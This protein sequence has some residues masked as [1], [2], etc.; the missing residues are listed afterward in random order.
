MGYDPAKHHRRSIRLKD[1]DYS[2]PGAYFITIVT[3]LRKC[4]LGSVSDNR[5]NLSPSGKIVSKKWNELPR[6]YRNIWLDR[7]VIMPNHLHGI[8]VII[9]RNDSLPVTI[10]EMIRGFKSF[11]AREINK[12]KK[13]MNMPVWQRNYYEHIIRDEQE[14]ATIRDYIEVN[15]L[16]W[17][18]D[19]EYLA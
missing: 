5:V 16:R 13:Q 1:Y 2:Q 6:H 12:T 9:E 18:D 4:I 11:S 19:P 15:P 8:L 17:H 14:W 3:G 10:S 7:Y